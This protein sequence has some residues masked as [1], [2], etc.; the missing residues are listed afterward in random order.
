MSFGTKMRSVTAILAVTLV[1]SALPVSPAEARPARWAPPVP[2]DVTP[3]DGVAP[4]TWRR[5]PTWSADAS[6]VRGDSEVVWPE[7]GEASVA[8]DAATQARRAGDLPVSV[9]PVAGERAAA[10]PAKVGVEVHSQAAS[11]KAGVFGVVFGVARADGVAAAAKSAVTVDYGRFATAGGG[12]WASR[13]RLVQLPAC[14]LTTPEAAGCSTATPLASTNDVSARTVTAVASL[15]AS[16]GATVMALTAAPEGD[17]GDYK[18]TSLASASTWDVSTQTGA[19]SWSMPLRM[20]PAV[21][22]PT[23]SLSLSYSSQTMDGR[24]GG[25]NTQGS[26]TGD[27]F[28]MWPGYI[29]RTYKSCSDD[30]G[31]VDGKDPNNKTKPTGDQCWW[32]PNATMSLN[33]RGTELVDA[34][35]GLWK[36]VSDDASKV[37]RLTGASNGDDDGEHWKV[38]T[39]D[40]TQYFFGRQAPA[41]STWTVEVFGNHPDDPGYA[42]G[43]FAGSRRTQAWRWNLDYVVDPHGNT[44][45]LFY[46]KEGGAY[47]RENDPNKRT[48]YD[49]GGYLTR[50]DYGGRADSSAP[51]AARVVFDVEDRCK[52]GATCN[53]GNGRPI[54]ASFPDTPL[55]Q[56]CYATPCTNQMYP[57]FWTQKR[58][59]KI[60]TQVHTGGGEYGNVESWALRHE[61]L[62][63]GVLKGEGI[64]MFLRGITHTG[65]VGTDVAE[66][67]I[68]FDPGSEPLPNRVDGPSDNRTALNR[69]RIKRVTTESG[70]QILVDYKPAQCTKATLP[71]VHANDKL[72]FPQY[73]APTGETPT[74]DWFHKYVVAKMTANDNAAGSDPQVTFFDY[75][76]APAWHFDDSELVKEDKR[77]WGGFRGFGHVRIRTGAESGPQLAREERFLR[78]MDGDKQPTGTRDVWVTDSWGNRIEDHK[79][80]AGMSLEQ[81]TLDGAGGAWLQGV[82]NTPSAPVRTAASGVLEAWMVNTSTTRTYSRTTVEPDGVRWSRTETKHN[83]DN[84][85]TEVDDLGDETTAAD[86]RC[87]RTWYARNP[88]VWMLDKVKR[89]ETV[90]VA[91][92]ATPSFPADMVSSSRT[93]YDDAGGNWDT[94]LPTRGLAAKVEEL[95]RWEGTSPRWVTTATTAYDANGRVTSA[96]DALGNTTKTAYTPELA[97]PVTKTEVRNPKDHKVTTTLAPAWSLPLTIVNPDGVATELTYDGLGRLKKAWLPGRATSDRAN[98]EFDYLVRNTAPSAVTTRTLLPSGSGHKTSIALYDGWLR[99]R[100]TQTQAP[101]GGRSI[102]E[103][104]YNSRAEKWWTSAPYYDKSGAAPDTTLVAASRSAIPSVTETIYDGGGRPT[105]ESLQGTDG[106]RWRTTTS[107]SGDV[108]IVTPPD[109]GTRTATRVDARGLTVESRRYHSR[110][111]APGTFDATT[112]TYTDGGKLATITDPARNVW[113]HF[114]DQRGREIRNEDPD[115]GITAAGYDAAGRQTSST[116]ANQVTL[117]TT[118]DELGRRETLR[119]GDADG[120]IRARWFYDSLPYG[121]GLL[122]KSVRYAGEQSYVNEVTG[123]DKAGHPT[124]NSVTIP[125]SEGSLCA[126]GGTTPCTFTTTMTYKADGQPSTTTLPKVG[127]LTAEQLTQNY[128]DVGTPATITSSSGTLMRSTYYDKTGRLTQRVLGALGKQ[129]ATDFTLDDTTNRLAEAK[130]ALENKPSPMQLAYSYDAAGNLKRIH[131]TPSGQATDTQCYGYDHL[132]R[133]LEAWTP[134]N[135]DCGPAPTV[136][137][138]GGPAAYWHSYEYTGAAGLTGSRTK[139]TW[140]AAGGDT[141]RTYT[142]PAQAGPAGSRPHALTK[143]DTD[144]ATTPDTVDSYTYHPSG[145]TKDRVLAG[146]TSR[147]GWDQENHLESVTTNGKT[148]SYVY[149]AD[150]GPLVRRDPTGTGT[151]LYLGQQE[152]NVPAGSSTAVGTRYYSHVGDPIGVRTKSAGL[153][154]L[155]GDH[156]DTGEVAIRSADLQAVRRRTLPFGGL[157]GPAPSGWPGDKAFVGGTSQGQGLVQVGARHYEP[158]TGRFVSVDPEID[159]TD[160]QQMH[161]YA[162]ANNAPGTFSDPTGRM[163]PIDDIGGGGGGGGSSTACTGTPDRCADQRGLN[164]PTPGGGTAPPGTPKKATRTGGGTMAMGDPT[165]EPTPEKEWPRKCSDPDQANCEMPPEWKKPCKPYTPFK[166]D[167][168]DVPIDPGPDPH[169][170]DEGDFWTAFTIVALDKLTQPIQDGLYVNGGFCGAGAIPICGSLEANSDGLVAGTAVGCCKWGG[171]VG[172]NSARPDEMAGPVNNICAAYGVGICYQTGLRQDGTRWHGGG[173]MIGVGFNWSASLPLGGKIFDW[174]W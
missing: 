20:V 67:E 153:T 77:T 60:R 94:T 132:R 16:N 62:D 151:T 116:D 133:L 150:G 32:K 154:F 128:D 11:A 50:I 173:L 15:T 100:Q 31:A 170:Y 23:P 163:Y 145:S 146:T 39:K 130:V 160:P 2:D 80:Y 25:N 118:Y 41:S 159:Q 71:A 127:D 95:D 35:G 64:P 126:A 99:E 48:T 63:A 36:G 45:T 51:A 139:E 66:P 165:P 105:V 86:D 3:V 74:L 155:V 135:G 101:G 4:A 102:T 24:T 117:A 91:C 9:A 89:T 140:H 65:H 40:G 108:T 52:P 47:G 147:L 34:G 96:A 144:N 109:G 157:R 1:S 22:G 61:W 56:Y 87:T 168:H 5:Q 8:L 107:Y 76:D 28:D 142:Y 88:A 123:Y 171:G 156:H 58:L 43:N 19:F 162:Y 78:G 70:A 161:G 84:L 14:A 115:K 55:D 57:T 169:D 6:R 97:G 72:C 26:W 134:G 29:E 124:G 141:K 37:E 82:V 53:D 42:A 93:T 30:T 33:G 54:P 120:T 46:G 12:D 167:C 138:L 166:V 129:V 158:A 113:K 164:N 13:L 27:G 10:S 44:M 81:T 111:G 121:T 49:R 90:G 75:L 104:H 103:T 131:D 149:D 7:A 119:E 59:A 21:G 152:V 18:A 79:A 137:A 136:A 106:E 110:V 17:N 38:T 114:Y 85:P 172:W 92:T 148:V 68:V 125:A 174:N 112:Y 98:L 122:T 83:A 69:W 73:Y 143:V